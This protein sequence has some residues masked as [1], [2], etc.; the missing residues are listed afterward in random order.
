MAQRPTPKPIRHH[1]PF[2]SFGLSEDLGTCQGCKRNFHFS[3]IE[4]IK[5][6]LLNDFSLGESDPSAISRLN[7]A[8]EAQLKIQTDHRVML[9]KQRIEHEAAEKLKRFDS[10]PKYIKSLYFK[11][12][13]IMISLTI[14]VCLFLGGSFIGS[15]IATSNESK[16]A[17]E[18]VEEFRANN[19][20]ARI[21]AI[22]LAT[23]ANKILIEV[24][25]FGEWER[26][27][28]S[29]YSVELKNL[30][31]DFLEKAFSSSCSLSTLSNES[32]DFIYDMKDGESN[33]EYFYVSDLESLI[34]ELGAY[35][36]SCI[37]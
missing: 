27:D 37:D 36:D 4:L 13:Q 9:E 3:E 17:E 11:R 12:K 31:T 20:V 25:G 28:W 5:A 23:Y 29:G 14:V 10:K 7:A 34:Q 8:I 2:C 6:L 22:N 33:S 18:K 24:D 30:T 26:I 19:E 16:N 21:S 15:F 32:S 1:C 35:S